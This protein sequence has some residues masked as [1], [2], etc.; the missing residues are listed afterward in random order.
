MAKGVI[1]FTIQFFLLK[2]KEQNN[3][4]AILL[5]ISASSVAKTTCKFPLEGKLNCVPYL[6][7]SSNMSLKHLYICDHLPSAKNIRL[8]SLSLLFLMLYIQIKRL[9]KHVRTQARIPRTVTSPHIQTNKHLH[10]DSFN[11]F[12]C[13]FSPPSQHIFIF[14]AASK[15]Q[16]GVDTRARL[17]V[18]ARMC[19]LGSV[20]YCACQTWDCRRLNL[21]PYSL[22]APPSPSLPAP[23]FPYPLPP[24]RKL[25]I[26]FA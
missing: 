18:P 7:I 4:T 8:I 11:M 5:R 26:Y 24:R 14:E 19:T 10:T 25:L 1:K 23:S 16:K 22:G 6:L 2:W 21:I 3:N 17:C 13:L 15:N 9:D 12:L 20:R